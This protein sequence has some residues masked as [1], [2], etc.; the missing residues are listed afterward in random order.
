MDSII[1]LIQKLRGE[2]GCAWDKKQ[3]PDSISNY[4]IEEVYELLEA[5]EAGDVDEIRNE[6]G[7]VLF[8]VLFLAELY[9]EKGAFEIED[10]IAENARKMIARHPHVFEKETDLSVSDIRKQWDTIKSKEKEASEKSAASVIDSVP[11]KLPPLMRAYNVSD[12]TARA[13]F[14]WD[15]MEGVMEKAEEEW[16][17]F[18]DALKKNSQR[19]M[20]LEFGD[21]LFTLTNVARFAKIHPDTAL[22]DSIRKFEKRYRY[23]ENILNEKGQTLDGISREKIDKL[24]DLAKEK[25]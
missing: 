2:N 16:F 18:K 4:L 12:R 11:R 5:I 9:R 19:D 7:D 24:W 13:G 15:D 17:E 3:T 8:Q 10:V 21:I 23:M 6:L 1:E 14:D 25:S 22:R 20:S